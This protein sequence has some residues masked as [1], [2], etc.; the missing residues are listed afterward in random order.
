MIKEIRFI[1]VRI[2]SLGVFK[3]KNRRG[4]KITDR[5]IRLILAFDHIIGPLED[6]ILD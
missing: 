6:V 1:N 4:W 3:A 5:G 2:K